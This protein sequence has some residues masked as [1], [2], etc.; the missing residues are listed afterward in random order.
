MYFMNRAGGSLLPAIMV[1]GLGN[2]AMGFSGRATIETALT[3]GHQITKALPFL[4]VALI[5]ILLSGSR[6]GRSQAL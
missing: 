2:D 1:H 3:P 4:M 5:L 6:L